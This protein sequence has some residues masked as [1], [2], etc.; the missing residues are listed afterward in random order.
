MVILSAVL[1]IVILA[2]SMPPESDREKE[3]KKF[4]RE[5]IEQEKLR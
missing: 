2:R 3:L 5:K 4:A 1:I